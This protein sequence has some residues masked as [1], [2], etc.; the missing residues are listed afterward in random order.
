MK[1]YEHTLL[2]YSFHEIK[3]NPIVTDLIIRCYA[4]FFCTKKV[5]TRN[6]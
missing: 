6:N 2:N 3:I 4:I 5:A 1:Y